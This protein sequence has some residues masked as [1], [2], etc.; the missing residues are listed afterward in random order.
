MKPVL[1]CTAPL[2]SFLLVLA[3]ATSLVA[4]HPAAAALPAGVQR[5]AGV[6]GVEAFHLANGLSVLLAPDPGKATVTVNV[7]YRVGSRNESYGETGMAHLLEHLMFKGTP[8]HPDITG[9]LTAH[10]MRPN[11]TTWYDRTNYFETFAAAPENLEWA[12]AMEADRMVHSNIAQH[13]LDSEMT[14]VRNEMERGENSPEGIL[15]ERTLAAAFQWHNYGKSTI[16]ARA[17]VENVSIARLQ[18][19]YRNWYQPDN[20]VLVVAGKFDSDATLARIEQVFGSIPRPA[21]ELQKTYTLDPVQEGER[22]VVLRRPGDLQHLD[23]VY[24]GVAAAAP[25]FAAFQ[26]LAAVMGDP[27]YGRLHQ[28][29]TTQ[30]LATTTGAAVYALRE[31]GMLE[32][33]VTLRKDQSLER[34]E[35]KALEVLEGLAQRPIT[36][37]EVERV[38]TRMLADF[39]KTF[40]DPERFGVA[41]S[42]AIA[43]GDWRLFFVLR[44][45]LRTVT[46]E[47]VQRV[48]LQ[49]LKASNRTLGR[50]IPVDHADN[51]PPPALA[52]VAA[53][54]RDFH[55]DASVSQGEAFDPSPEN[56][57]Q[58]L[59]RSELPGGLKLVMLPKRTRGHTVSARLQLHWGTAESLRGLATV[60]QLAGSLLD[61]GG[62]G[63]S[64]EQIR[65]RFDQLQAKVSLGGGPTGVSV[66]IETVAEH[67]P[68]ALA[69]AARLLREPAYPDAEFAQM[70]GEMLAGAE[71]GRKDPQSMAMRALSIHLDHY[72]ADDIRHAGTLDED[73]AALNAVTREQITAFQQRFFCAGHGEVAVVGDFDPAAVDTALRAGLDGWKCS[74]TYTPVLDEFAAPRP[75]RIQLETPGKANAVLYARLAFP[76]RDDDPDAALL[77]LGNYILGEGFL[78]SRLATRIRQKEGLS[79]GVGSF[80]HLNRDVADSSFGAYA[81]Y[82]PE[83]RERLERAFGEELAR[84]LR[85]GYSSAEVDAARQSLLQSRRLGRAQDGGLAGLLTEYLRLGRTMAFSQQSD[86][87][88]Q[89]ATPEALL[90][91]MRKWIDPARL[92]TVLAGDFARDRR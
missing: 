26:V 92:T 21:R 3:A 52:D 24:H 58:H 44:N 84:V 61:R 55:P 33:T 13:D 66:A 76:L 50:G 40:A 49:W 17:D 47:Q 10:G 64:R 88:I 42:G 91:A 9:G 5:D 7:T 89:Q 82:A 31:P 29:L 11:G 23:I 30:A 19:F 67:L 70:R 78:N 68:Q 63:L 72:P 81:I 90:A 53:R 18:A 51:S 73:I 8:Q 71:E 1:Y 25:D 86:E 60:G 14:V 15:S 4:S 80:L 2:R 85:D 6:E 87:R 79:Y 48:G 28:A 43:A 16:G 12:L 75:E 45:D 57:E 56:I 74:E 34:A 36:D 77:T 38:R 37:K 35:S 39:D 22:V 54:L 46:A 83:N 32:V 62:A 27:P 20:A 59:Q 65:E 41:L 69:L